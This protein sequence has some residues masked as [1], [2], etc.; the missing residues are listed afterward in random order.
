MPGERRSLAGRR[1]A[2]DASPAVAENLVVF[3]A[4][5]AVLVGRSY[6][7]VRPVLAAV[8]FGCAS[9][10]VYLVNDVIDA[11]RDRRHPVNGIVPIAPVLMHAR[12][13]RWRVLP[14]AA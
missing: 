3:A 4:P 11:E 13:R 1:G 8:A 2:H 7:F 12:G 10:A 5:L 14:R 6:G 9:A